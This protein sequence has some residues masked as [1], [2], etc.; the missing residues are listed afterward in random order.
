[1]K[2]GEGGVLEKPKWSIQRGGC[3][4]ESEV[5]GGGGTHQKTHPSPCFSE[6]KGDEFKAASILISRADRGTQKRNVGACGGVVWGLG[7]GKNA[8]LRRI[9][10][11]KEGENQ[12]KTERAEMFWGE[13]RRPGGSQNVGKRRAKGSVVERRPREQKRKAG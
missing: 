4:M 5:E 6:V 13:V 11:P 3:V 8:M 2:G 1:V 7:S 10:P 12:S 9:G